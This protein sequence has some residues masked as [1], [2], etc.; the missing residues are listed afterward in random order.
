MSEQI[1]DQ[2]ARIQA[3]PP[4]FEFDMLYTPQNR[5]FGVPYG[6][7]FAV[8]AATQQEAINKASAALGDAQGRVYK[9][10]VRGVKD[11]QLRTDSGNRG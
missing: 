8:V 5:N 10:L 4:Q 6:K 1:A 3:R 7:P 11:A 9:F 2:V